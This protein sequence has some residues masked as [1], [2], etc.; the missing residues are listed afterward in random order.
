MPKNTTLSTRWA[1]KNFIDWFCEYNVKNPDSKCP[2]EVLLPS[3][4][5]EVLNKW[6]SVYVAETRSHTG[7]PYPATSLYSLL[8]GILRHMK[9]ENPSYPN[10]WIK[11]Y[12]SFL[13]SPLLL[14]ICSRTC[15]HQVLFKF[16]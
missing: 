6:L 7:E 2:E 14:I 15:V 16:K 11:A 1:M 5:A 12:L 4:S 10:F 13:P 8:L 3:C 9:S